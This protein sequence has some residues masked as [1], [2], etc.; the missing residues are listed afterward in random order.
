[1]SDDGNLSD[2][3]DDNA[4]RRV[5]ISQK[6]IGYSPSFVLFQLFGALLHIF[7]LCYDLYLAVRY[8]QEGEFVY[9]TLVSLFGFLSPLCVSLLS[10]CINYKKENN[11]FQNPNWLKFLNWICHCLPLA[12]VARYYSL[13]FL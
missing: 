9:C 4:V 3:S 5:I 1:M 11:S 13:L 6:K 2:E 10:C 12:P 8:Y 7:D